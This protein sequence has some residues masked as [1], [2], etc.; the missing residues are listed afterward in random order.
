MNS[1][2]PGKTIKAKYPAFLDDYAYLIRALIDLQEISADHAWLQKAK[3]IVEYAIG[4][5][6]EEDTGFFFYTAAGQK[7]VILRKKEV[8]D[9]ALPSG[10]SIWRIICIIFLYFLI[11]Q[12]GKKDLWI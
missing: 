5:F 1:I 3:A 7:D 12:N 4:H 9:G 2:I 11:K 6:S 8:Y 10:N